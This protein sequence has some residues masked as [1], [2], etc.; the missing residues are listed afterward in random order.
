[1]ASTGTGCRRDLACGKRSHGA[2]GQ[3][4]LQFIIDRSLM[5]PRNVL[6]AIDR[7]KGSAINL[8]HERIEAEDIDKGVASYSGDLLIEAD[9][10]LTDVAPK[11]EWSTLSIY[12][13]EGCALK[14]GFISVS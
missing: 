1:M 8:R 2:G 11:A 5:R 3:E 7:C 14:R 9:R 6:K 10:E 13:R 4:T 12:R